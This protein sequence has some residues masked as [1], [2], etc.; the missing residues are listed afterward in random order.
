MI[1]ISQN[2]MIKLLLNGYHITK[3]FTISDHTDLTCVRTRMYA[4]YV[5]M[6]VYIRPSSLLFLE[7]FDFVLIT[8]ND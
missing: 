5:R 4:F 1:M 2:N 8:K 7:V 3:I 6:Y